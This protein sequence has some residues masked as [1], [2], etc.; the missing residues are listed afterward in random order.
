M[1]KSIW[2]AELNDNNTNTGEY[3]TLPSGE[4]VFQV[5]KVTG[6][7]YSPKP[8]AKMK[9]CA[10]IDVQMRVEDGKGKE[11]TV[12]DHLYSDPI[13]IWK[14]TAFAKSIGVFKPGMTPGRLLKDAEDGIGKAYFI[15]REAANGYSARN[16]VR[17]Y[18]EK[19]TVPAMDE[20]LP[21]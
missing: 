2:D 19:E 14:M 9:K 11:I 17:R 20:E 7:E 13:A 5:V 18:I 21:F 15:Y 16:E 8:G 4:Y 6:K 10:E 1:A 12:F 3:P